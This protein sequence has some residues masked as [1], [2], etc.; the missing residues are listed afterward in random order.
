MKRWIAVRLKLSDNTAYTALVALRSTGIDVAHVERARLVRAEGVS[1]A[2]M[3]A[4]VERDEAIFNT[5]LH[6]AHVREADH[7]QAG[8]IWVWPRD[9]GGDA[10][11][12]QL[13]DGR[14]A[15]LDTA[16]LRRACDALLCNPAIEEARYPA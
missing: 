7:P 13:R 1:E 8:E 2:A 9:A 11:S 5:H 4:A 6:E 3:I 12:W 16:T 14:G 15:P 10:W